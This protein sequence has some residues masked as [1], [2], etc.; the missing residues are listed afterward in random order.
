MGFGDVTKPGK[1]ETDRTHEGCLCPGFARKAW[2]SDCVFFPNL[3]H[4]LAHP[5][6]YD[7]HIVILPVIED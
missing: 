4:E 2:S 1:T 5:V 3:I 7:S 6:Y